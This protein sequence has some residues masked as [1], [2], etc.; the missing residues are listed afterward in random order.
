MVGRRETT[1]TWV[2]KEKFF[3]MLFC[4]VWL[5]CSLFSLAFLMQSLPG[6]NL[7]ADVVLNYSRVSPPPFRVVFVLFASIGFVVD[8]IISPW[9]TPVKKL[10]TLKLVHLCKSKQW[11]GLDGSHLDHQLIFF[12]LCSIATRVRPK[13]LQGAPWTDQTDDDLDHVGQIR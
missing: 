2:T 7:S 1:E 12:G 10:P 6:K 11:T 3:L 13:G 9:R 5:Y 8:C 4:S